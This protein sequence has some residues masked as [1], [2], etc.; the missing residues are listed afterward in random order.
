MSIMIPF[1]I[2]FAVFVW[3]R[4]NVFVDYFGQLFKTKNILYVGDYYKDTLSY[5]LEYPLWLLTRHPNFVTKLITCPICCV[6]WLNGICCASALKFAVS[7][8]L[9]NS[10]ISLLAFVILDRGYKK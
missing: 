3:L 4:T 10:F 9:F 8:W 6:F 7:L 2:T 5:A 1:A